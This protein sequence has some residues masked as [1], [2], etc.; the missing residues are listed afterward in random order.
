MSSTPR[1]KYKLI[2][3]KLN[4]NFMNDSRYVQERI[5]NI[6]DDH[7]IRFRPDQSVF[8]QKHIIALH[9]KLDEI[10]DKVSSMPKIKYNFLDN[11]QDRLFINRSERVKNDIIS[12][13]EPLAGIGI[14]SCS[15]SKADEV[16]FNEKLLSM[17]PENTVLSNHIKYNSHIHNVSAID[18]VIDI[19]HKLLGDQKVYIFIKGI[20]DYYSH[21]KSNTVNSGLRDNINFHDQSVSFRHLILTDN[22]LTDKC[23]VMIIDILKAIDA[24]VT[25]NMSENSVSRNGLF[26]L[27]EYFI[28]SKVIKKAI[29]DK[30]SIS[31]TLLSLFCNKLLK[32]SFDI[33]NHQRVISLVSLSLS[34]NQIGDGG[35]EIL[36]KCLSNGCLQLVELDLSWNNIHAVGVSHLAKA[37]TPSNDAYIT[38]SANTLISLDLSWNS[39]V[40]SETTL[41][42]SSRKKS[43][44]IDDKAD[45]QCEGSKSLSR[46]FEFN[47]SLTHVNLSYNRLTVADCQ[48]I[49]QG[50]ANNHT[51]LGLHMSG[52]D[53]EV[54]SFVQLNPIMKTNDSNSIYTANDSLNSHFKSG[55]ITRSSG[56]YGI[57]KSW[58]HQPNC[59]ICEGWREWKFSLNIHP[60]ILMKLFSDSNSTRAQI[61]SPIA[62][63]LSS[64][65]SNMKNLNQTKDINVK[66]LTVYFLSSFDNWM[67]EIMSPVN[68][69]GNAKPNQKLNQFRQNEGLNDGEIVDNNIE[70]YAL[71]PSSFYLQEH[72]TLEEIRL[73][74]KQ[75]YKVLGSTESSYLQLLQQKPAFDLD[76]SNLDHLSASL[77]GGWKINDD[78]LDTDDSS[79][80]GFSA[81]IR[82]SF[83]ETHNEINSSKTISP[84][85]ISS[86]S[87]A[88]SAASS[89]GSLI[90]S[91]R[92]GMIQGPEFEIYRMVPPGIHY[93]GFFV[94]RKQIS[95]EGV[96]TYDCNQPYVSTAQLKEAVSTYVHFAMILFVY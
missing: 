76:D 12:D 59:W 53:C 89:N 17:L 19:S 13:V 74:R 22:R 55:T 65:Q 20:E 54:N 34:K 62:I 6:L 58:S 51:V 93:F 31:D 52:N 68:V 8:N 28:S 33:L 49:N 41:L 79:Q 80:G 38:T 56:D 9:H 95:S 3:P 27:T 18:G 67:Y 84:L 24:F 1:P 35:I 96:F 29:L 25:I 43:M 75:N 23:I 81:Q 7:N 5:K 47:I 16:S 87:I 2:S 69:K 50:L 14:T 37:L 73:I 4:D 83:N 26:S 11:T 60:N 72:L 90:S 61:S 71:R 88:K 46:L 57:L 10:K 66:Q 78:L 44:N 42:N 45:E 32:S 30:M 82:K 39:F 77:G 15:N 63:P 48:I 64:T 36:S 40:S 92:N 94:M 91:E 21:L 70:L 86:S 85:S